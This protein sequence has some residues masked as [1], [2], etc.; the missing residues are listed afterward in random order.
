MLFF[1][2]HLCYIGDFFSLLNLWNL[3]RLCLHYI[4]KII[5]INTH[6][7]KL[8]WRLLF[9]TDLFYKTLWHL[10]RGSQCFI[11][12]RSI[13]LTFFVEYPTFLLL[14]PKSTI[15]F[16]FCLQTE[17]CFI[18]TYLPVHHVSSEITWF[19]PFQG[20]SCDKMH[21]KSF[22]TLLQYFSKT[23][24]G[25]LGPVIFK[26]QHV[27]IFWEGRCLIFSGRI[28]SVIIIWQDLMRKHVGLN[29]AAVI[30]PPAKTSIIVMKETLAKDKQKSEGSWGSLFNFSDA[31]FI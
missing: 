10:V 14:S 13:I 8:Q 25:L 23:T 19:H 16:P 29:L 26:E 15:P 6:F 9:R 7:Q 20:L 17:L 27:S 11:S 2:L 18:Q 4:N 28:R 3:F 1:C 31:Y 12:I 5:I 30:L 24:R 21:H 22:L